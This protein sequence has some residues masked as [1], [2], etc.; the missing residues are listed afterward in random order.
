MAELRSRCQAGLEGE[1]GHGEEHEIGRSCGVKKTNALRETPQGGANI[2]A[3]EDY[4]TIEELNNLYRNLGLF[5][6]P[7]PASRAAAPL[8]L[9]TTGA[10]SASSSSSDPSCAAAAASASSRAA[11]RE[12]PRD[13]CALSFWR[14]LCAA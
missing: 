14:A 12:R 1:G 10:G 6:G 3:S 2:H 7:P 5:R 13:F 8:L 9:P 11:P 4:L